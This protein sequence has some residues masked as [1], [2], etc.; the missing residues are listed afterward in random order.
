MPCHSVMRHKVGAHKFA[1][2][3]L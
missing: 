2:L 3:L 1:R